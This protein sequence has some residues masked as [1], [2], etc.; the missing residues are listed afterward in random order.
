MFLISGSVG[1]IVENVGKNK[2]SDSMGNSVVAKKLPYNSRNVWK[3]RL[4]IMEGFDK[5]IS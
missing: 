2:N 1:F 5:N 4:A 3:F